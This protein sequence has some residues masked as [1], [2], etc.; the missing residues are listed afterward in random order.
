MKDCGLRLEKVTGEG[1]KVLDYALLFLVP[2]VAVAKLLVL[3][4]ER[5]LAQKLVNRKEILPHLLS[6][7]LLADGNL[8][9][10][11][12]KSKAPSGS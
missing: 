5:H 3:N 8:I 10:V 4:R 9:L 1:R 2:L 6:L 7:P 12:K 11:A